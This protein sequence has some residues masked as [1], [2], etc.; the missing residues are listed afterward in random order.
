MTVD[1]HEWMKQH[2]ELL[3]TYMEPLLG[4][5]WPA[6]FSDV[7]RY[8]LFGGGKRVRP[9]ITMAVFKALGHDNLAPAMAPG[10]AVEMIHTYSL[11]HD[12]L[13]AMDDDDERRGRPTVHKAYDEAMAILA[14]DALLTEA[15]ELL[16]N[17]E[18]HNPSTKIEM[19]AILARASGYRGM[20]GGQVADIRL[21]GGDTTADTLERIHRLKTGALLQ[22]AAVLG[23]L[24]AGANREQLQAIQTYGAALGFAFQLADDI[25]DADQDD[26]DEGNPSY[27][28]L[29]G[30]DETR[31]WA[32]KQAEI[33]KEA[34]R[35]LPEPQ[36]LIDLAT[37]TVERT[38]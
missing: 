22:C 2:R 28:R 13:P 1:L 11:V 10:A 31:A 17:D 38:V 14:G 29:L 26:G 5:S 30:V 16:A 21:G 24:A 9:L 32:H 34:A 18:H 20:V 7:M 15:F 36:L 27:V 37:F 3:D 33:A 12:D 23:G 8:P 4:D 6:D 35:Q 25:L 19:V